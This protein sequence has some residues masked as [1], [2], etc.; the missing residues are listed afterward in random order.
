LIADLEF[1]LRLR[2]VG[3]KQ[4][5]FKEFTQVVLMRSALLVSHNPRFLNGENLIKIYE[6]AW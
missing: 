2:D 5:D 3:V 1:P 6:M 4:E